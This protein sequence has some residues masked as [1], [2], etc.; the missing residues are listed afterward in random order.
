LRRLWV[1]FA[2]GLGVL[3]LCGVVLRAEELVDRVAARVNSN[4]VLLSEV[5]GALALGVVAGPEPQAIER[6]IER[7]LLLQEVLR[8]PPAEPSQGAIDAEHGRL[9]ATAGAQLDRILA[10][11]GLTVESIR[12]MARDSL[13]IQAYLDQRFGLT[14]PL[15]DG[16][17]AEYYRTHQDA[18]RR[19]GVVRPFDEAEPDVR[20]LAAQER[21]E[22]TV[23]QWVQDLRQRAEVTLPRFQP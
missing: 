13:R 15:T 10:T 5:R 2:E 23:M 19:D 22:M 21:R 16:Q 6:M 17:V 7:T 11:T 3:L 8:F 14:V 4:V 9:I 18:F 20:R 12:D 1:V